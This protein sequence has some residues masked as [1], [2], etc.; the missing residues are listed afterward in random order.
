MH[1]SVVAETVDAIHVAVGL[2]LMGVVLY[3]AWAE[4]LPPAIDAPIE[5]L[6]VIE[7]ELPAGQ[8]A[9][10]AWVAD[11]A[12]LEALEQARLLVKTLEEFEQDPPELYTEIA[13]EGRV[14]LNLAGI[15]P[16]RLSEIRTAQH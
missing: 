2:R 6:V 10:Q 7:E 5:L 13:R 12:P 4:P 16:Q 1:H 14:L 9:R 11:R 3:G 8:P 15:V